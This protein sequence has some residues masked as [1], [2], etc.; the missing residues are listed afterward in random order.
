MAT[1]SSGP[2]PSRDPTPKELAIPAENVIASPEDAPVQPQ[3][4]H[5]SA[6]FRREQLLDAAIAVM[7][8]HGVAGATTRAIT[9]RAGV[10]HGVFH[11]CFRSKVELFA[12]LFEREISK[13][14]AST[15]AALHAEGDVRRGLESALT[16]QLD[17]VR[18]EPEY[19][20]ALAELSLTIQRTDALAPLAAWEQQQYRER[21]RTGLD[22]W[23][24]ALGLQW[25][26]PL[27]SLAS[28][29]V[30]TGGGIASTWLADRDDHHA[31]AAV[32][33]AAAA[34]S[35]LHRESEVA[36]APP[37]ETAGSSVATTLL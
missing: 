1:F 10:P 6:D 3:G 15:G 19:H 5:R 13:T 28:L 16:A 4:S 34:L 22:Q 8:E 29:L 20:L 14:L 7:S 35:T 21:V 33:V 11:Y 25:S 17:R 2:V 9:E 32:D 30:I 18:R 27:E 36:D 37:P 12:A 24:T 23:S 31:E 26:V